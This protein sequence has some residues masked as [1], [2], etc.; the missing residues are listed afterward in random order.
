MRKLCELPPENYAE[1]MGYVAMNSLVAYGRTAIR[2]WEMLSMMEPLTVHAWSIS[3][4]ST[5]NHFPLLKDTRT[6]CSFFCK[7]WPAVYLGKNG[8]H[9]RFVLSQPMEGMM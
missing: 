7:T 4:S 3:K 5:R 1:R 9:W 2:I 6:I 8:C